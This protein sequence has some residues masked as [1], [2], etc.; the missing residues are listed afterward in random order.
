MNPDMNH[1]ALEPEDTS[2]L[3][4]KPTQ[5]TTELKKTELVTEEPST[6]PPTETAEPKEVEAQDTSGGSEEPRLIASS[7]VLQTG[8]SDPAEQQ[9]GPNEVHSDSIEVETQPAQN[10]PSPAKEAILSRS[11]KGFL[12]ERPAQ[13]MPMPSMLVLPAPWLRQQRLDNSHCSSVTNFCRF[14]MTEAQQTILLKH[15]YLA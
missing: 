14:F 4:P 9:L 1:D 8:T 13:T 10:A 3:S 6:P 2:A 15:K 5:E 12:Q 11:P 7:Q